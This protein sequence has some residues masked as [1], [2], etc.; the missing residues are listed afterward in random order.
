MGEKTW[1]S[2]LGATNFMYST[3]PRVGTE[4]LDLLAINVQLRKL[5]WDSWASQLPRRSNV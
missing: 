5:G 1:E 2:Y 3:L 4:V